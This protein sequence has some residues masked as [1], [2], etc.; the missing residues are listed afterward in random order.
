MCL[1]RRDEPSIQDPDFI[2]VR[3]SGLDFFPVKPRPNRQLT[4][5]TSHVGHQYISQKLVRGSPIASKIPNSRRAPIRMN[6]RLFS[7][8]SVREILYCSYQQVGRG[9]SSVTPRG[10]GRICFFPPKCRPV[11]SGRGT[12]TWRQVSVR[13]FGSVKIGYPNRALCSTDFAYPNRTQM[14]SPPARFVGSLFRGK[15]VASRALDATNP[16]DLD[17]N[18]VRRFGSSQTRRSLRLARS[19]SEDRSRVEKN[20]FFGPNRTSERNLLS[21]QS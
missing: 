12:P 2:S 1:N 18:S 4:N 9:I 11:P 17:L 8:D 21:V 7:P 3:F 6:F 14:R 16:S 13:L 20:G 19:R 10:V 5:R 15:Q